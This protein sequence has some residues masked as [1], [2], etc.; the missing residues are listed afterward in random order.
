MASHSDIRLRY[1]YR[2]CLKSTR[3]PPRQMTERFRVS[4]S[5]P[6]AP[7]MPMQRLA[8]RARIQLEYANRPSPADRH[9]IL[10]RC[11][12]ARRAKPARSRRF[13]TWQTSA[14]RHSCIRPAIR[15]HRVAFEDGRYR[16]HARASHDGLVTAMLLGQPRD[17]ATLM[18]AGIPANGFA[19][20]KGI[21][22]S[23]EI[24]NAS[25]GEFAFA[26][27]AQIRYNSGSAKTV[28]EGQNS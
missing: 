13:R 10:A 14:G 6:T 27:V 17:W 25:W 12:T 15:G 20:L 23:P 4:G 7:A 18:R 22:V 21:Q 16:R 9:A 24:P 3:Q 26:P 19:P 8:S 11:I 2:G 5:V 1:R 28:R